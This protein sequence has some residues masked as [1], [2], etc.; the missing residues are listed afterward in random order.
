MQAVGETGQIASGRLLACVDRMLDERP[1]QRAAILRR[2]RDIQPELYAL[3][4]MRAAAS[5]RLSL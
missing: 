4:L 5:P 2:L 1:E 3:W